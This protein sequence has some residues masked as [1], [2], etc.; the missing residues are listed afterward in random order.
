M[1]YST[2][3]PNPASEVTGSMMRSLAQAPGGVHCSSVAV[4]VSC[5]ALVQIHTYKA[6]FPGPLCFWRLGHCPEVLYVPGS[7][8][9]LAHRRH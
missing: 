2:N 3:T 5:H 1:Y 9:R 7:Q 8:Y 4:L 6:V